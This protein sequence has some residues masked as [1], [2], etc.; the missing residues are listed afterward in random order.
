MV[1]AS[2]LLN[3]LAP[4]LLHST[5]GSCRWRPEVQQEAGGGR[6]GGLTVGTGLGN[7]EKCHAGSEVSLPLC[8]Y[9][10]VNI[11]WPAGGVHRNHG[12]D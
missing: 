10:G 9:F 1:P 12:D 8:H 11:W 5:G 7:I 3:S 2:W 6:E 4:G